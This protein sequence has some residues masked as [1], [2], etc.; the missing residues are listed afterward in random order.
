VSYYVD[1]SRDMVCGEAQISDY[2]DF[3]EAIEKYYFNKELRADHGTKC[4]EHILAE[5]KWSDIASKLHGI[6]MNVVGKEDANQDLLAEV[7]KID[8]SVF[9]LLESKKVIKICSLCSQEIPTL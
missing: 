4:R 3:V 2:A 9:T 7:E 1:N 6:I 5:Y 8:T